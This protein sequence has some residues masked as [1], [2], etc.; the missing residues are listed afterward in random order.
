[1]HFSPISN[2]HF[3]NDFQATESLLRSAEND[4][5]QKQ[6]FSSS[7]VTNGERVVES[8]T[9]S[10]RQETRSFDGFRVFE[11]VLSK[12]YQRTT[13][14]EKVPSFEQGAIDSEAITSEKASNNILGF[15]EAQLKRDVA[16]GASEEELVA[17]A[18]TALNAFEKGFNEAKNELRASGLLSQSVEDDIHATYDT[19]TRGIE[20]LKQGLLG[21]K[22][23]NETDRNDVD[24]NA[25]DAV[26]SAPKQDVPNA[27]LEN[28]PSRE[29]QK[30]SGS[31]SNRISSLAQQRD[32]F[33]AEAEQNILGS[34]NQTASS[35]S[36][37]IDSY[38]NYQFAQSN[39]FSFE[40]ETADGDKVTVTANTKD[41]YA[42]ENTAEYFSETSEFTQGFQFEVSGELDEDELLA[43]NDLFRQVERLSREFFSGDLD[44]AFSQAQNL[45]YDTEEIVG[46]SLNLRQVEVE[47]VRVAYDEFAPN[48]NQESNKLID[49]LQPIG[50]FA[51]GLLDALEPASKFSQ[52][53]R[54]IQ[55]LASYIEQV[56]INEELG[57]DDDELQEVVEPEVPAGS[58][59]SAAKPADNSENNKSE[60][61]D[62]TFFQTDQNRFAPFIKTILESLRQ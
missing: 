35:V 21:G 23:T 37:P 61:I 52:P 38:A 48:G 39:T 60:V 24:S 40:V 19:V 57:Q 20:N 51:Q 59:P 3:S 46:Y 22:T 17:R 1:M 62:N 31:G 44:A 54:L 6:S 25:S 26:E 32:S 18:E 55:H 16:N 11:S 8:Y 10:Y 50:N 7:E 45:G 56:K 28:N 13:A 42:A 15:I 43:L 4:V 53:T 34:L 33:A 14:S 27:A 49:A 12:S 30:D 41:L 58:S 29:N 47:R 9:E 36:A 2:H 5:E